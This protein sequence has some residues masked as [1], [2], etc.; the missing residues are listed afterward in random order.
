MVKKEHSKLGYARR[1]T[2]WQLWPY[3]LGLLLAFDVLYNRLA[4]AGQHTLNFWFNSD[5]LFAADVYKDVFVDKFPFSGLKFSVAPDIF[6]DVMVTSALMFLTR[7][8]IVATFLYGLIQF[9]LL[10]SAYVLCAR[11]IDGS[12]SEVSQAPIFLTG[13]GV[14][15]WT[16]SIVTFPYHTLYYLFLDQSHVS[17][18][19]LGIICGAA[20]TWLCFT[21]LQSKAARSAWPPW[22]KSV[23]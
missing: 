8:A 13:I 1:L 10:V 17:S 5:Y 7:N 22:P 9:T 3:W 20:G 4:A 18:T 21:S 15:L 16:A 14:A 11:V 19:A 12:R 23:L 2:G 6:P